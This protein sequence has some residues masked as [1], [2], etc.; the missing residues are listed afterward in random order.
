MQ[1]RL[2]SRKKVSQISKKAGN[3]AAD[4]IERSFVLV[5]VIVLKKCWAARIL[6]WIRPYAGRD[7]ITNELKSFQEM[8]CSQPIGKVDPKLACVCPPESANREIKKQS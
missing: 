3:V 7:T 4:G 5:G 8:E 1:G 2:E 6:Q